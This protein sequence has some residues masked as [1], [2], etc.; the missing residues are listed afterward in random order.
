[1]DARLDDFG[2]TLSVDLVDAP[3]E[4]SYSIVAYTYILVYQTSTTSCDSVKELY[5]Y[6]Q[7]FS[8]DPEAHEWSVRVGFAPL[9]ENVAKLI[10]SRVLDAMTF[11][12]CIDHGRGR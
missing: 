5:R 9:S 4:K 11:G 6:I 10:Q 3:G 2:D 12:A 7:W 8:T 1:M